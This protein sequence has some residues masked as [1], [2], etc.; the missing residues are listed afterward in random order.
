MLLCF[1]KLT[2][3]HQA[4]KKTNELGNDLVAIKN[5]IFSFKVWID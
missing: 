2:C 1:E 3:L 5:V 4:E